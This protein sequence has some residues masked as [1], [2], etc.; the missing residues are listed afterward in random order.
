M[1]EE[2]LADL[3]VELRTL[4]RLPGNQRTPLQEARLQVVTQ[5]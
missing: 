3:G 1:K 4:L 5:R 2:D